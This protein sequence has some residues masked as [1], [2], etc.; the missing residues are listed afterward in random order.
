MSTQANRNHVPRDGGE[1]IPL[2]GMDADD[3]GLQGDERR[4][5]HLPG[6]RASGRHRSRHAHDALGRGHALRARGP[7]PVPARRGHDI[8]RRGRHHAPARRRPTR[9]ARGTERRAR[10]SSRRSAPRPTAPT[11]RCSASCPR[12]GLR[13]RSATRRCALAMASISSSRWS[14]PARCCTTADAA[15][16]ITRMAS[17][18]VVGREQERA[19]VDALLAARSGGLLLCGEPGIGKTL[20]WE[21]GVRG[22]EDGGWTVLVHRSARA[23]T[24]FAFAGLSD[25]LAPVVDEALDGLP[26]PRRRAL[27]VAL[28]L[29][30]P[31]DASAPD[32]RAIG[33]ALLDVLRVAGRAGAGAAG[34]GR[35]A[36]ARRLVCRRAVRGVAP[37]AAT[38][39]SQCSARCGPRPVRSCRRRL[40][41]MPL[42]RLTLE[43]LDLAAVHRLLRDRLGLELPRPQ[44]ARIH[45]AAGG[46]PYFALELARE[47]RRAR[48]GQ[49]PRGAR[50][51]ARP[52][53]AR[54]LGDAPRRRRARDPDRAARRRAR[55]AR[56]SGRRGDPAPRRRPDPL[57]PP[58]ARVARVRPRAALGPPRRA[59]APGWAW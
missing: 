2:M 10:G 58:A 30:E 49:P 9:L 22:A 48:S 51:P 8:A 23:E 53:V 45:R 25:L 15:E 24:A 26:A 35:R 59:R 37:A 16:M 7:H 39:A 27:E 52:A 44:L 6:E 40:P 55:R 50:A 11:R 32:A 12:W 57:R 1:H 18:P 47:R 4:E 13:T 34:A 5:L 36:V 14:R 33:L 43:P 38:S 28:L 3:Q 17:A 46:N 56:R 19:V 54:R 42:E 20:L 29:A 21:Q 31:H 41:G